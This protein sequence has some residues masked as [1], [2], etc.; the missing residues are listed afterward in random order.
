MDS[1]QRRKVRKQGHETADELLDKA[2]Q[3][4][5]AKRQGDQGHGRLRGDAGPTTQSL[6][7]ASAARG[8][9]EHSRSRG[10]EVPSGSVRSGGSMGGEAT[11]GSDSDEPTATILSF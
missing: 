10:P 3:E 7:G 8:E 1:V 5:E 2:V 11:P 9:T 6:D 4:T